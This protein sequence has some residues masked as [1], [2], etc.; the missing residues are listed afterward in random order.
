MRSTNYAYSA[1]FEFFYRKGKVPAECHK[2]SK[3]AI[4]K[5]K[6]GKSLAAAMAEL[7]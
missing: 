7:V 3:I 4:E 1:A 5:Y 6:K 2:L